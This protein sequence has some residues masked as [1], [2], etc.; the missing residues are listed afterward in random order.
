MATEKDADKKSPIKITDEE[1]RQT[2]KTKPK[3]SSLLP[4][5]FT[6]C[7]TDKFID[8]KKIPKL[9]INPKIDD[10][11]SAEEYRKTE[12]LLSPIKMVM[13]YSGQK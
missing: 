1:L 12:Q 13:E 2:W 5:P 7:N 3:I 6:T 11:V 9:L 4:L 10:A 8:S